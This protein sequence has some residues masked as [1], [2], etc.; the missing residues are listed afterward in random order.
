LKKLKKC[1]LRRIFLGAESGSDRML[2]VI[3]KN[4]SVNM[5]KKVNL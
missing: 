4:I 1:G 2:R 3:N 5:I